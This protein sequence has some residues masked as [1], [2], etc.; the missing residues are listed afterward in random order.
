MNKGFI[1]TGQLGDVAELYVPHPPKELMQERNVLTLPFFINGQ[2]GVPLAK[3]R[4][5]IIFEYYPK[6][7]NILVIETYMQVGLCVYRKLMSMREV[8]DNFD[9]K[10]EFM[11]GMFFSDFLNHGEVYD[12]YCDY[13]TEI[14]ALTIHVPD[15]EAE[16]EQVPGEDLM[17]GFR[18][19]DV[20]S[21]G[22]DDANPEGF[23]N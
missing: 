8:V 16:R 2:P 20:D 4:V 13:M 7:G 10:K 9:D 3:Q 22:T 23:L 1:E 15:F 21:V 11:I 17:E 5:N 6:A 19:I 18:E 14:G 12:V